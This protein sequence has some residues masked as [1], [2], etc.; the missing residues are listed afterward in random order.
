MKMSEE[1]ENDS[2]KDFFPVKRNTPRKII[3]FL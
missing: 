3:I 1:E 2:R